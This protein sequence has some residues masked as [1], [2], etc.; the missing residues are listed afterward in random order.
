MTDLADI[1]GHVLR[2]LANMKTS[3]FAESA[4][5]T[6]FSV[7]SSAAMKIFS[8]KLPTARQVVSL[9]E[10]LGD[11]CPTVAEVRSALARVF[12][13]VV[14]VAFISSVGWR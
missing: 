12:A 1:T 10:I 13:Q 14:F 7:E 3:F 9:H 2:S 8:I 5:K 11:A 6:S 4:M